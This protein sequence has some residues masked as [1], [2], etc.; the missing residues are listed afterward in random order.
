[1]KMKDVR[2]SQMLVIIYQ[3]MLRNNPGDLT[4]PPPP[5]FR[6]TIS[7]MSPENLAMFA[8]CDMESFNAILTELNKLQVAVPYSVYKEMSLNKQ[9]LNSTQIT[10]HIL[11]AKKCR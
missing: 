3:G 4:L 5:H 2:S 1:M 8:F 10:Y 7:G 11:C 6:Q 9:K